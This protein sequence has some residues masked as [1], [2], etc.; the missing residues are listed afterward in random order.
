MVVVKFIL[1][2]VLY[3]VHRIA[4]INANVACQKAKRL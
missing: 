4:K 1:N 3:G 2:S